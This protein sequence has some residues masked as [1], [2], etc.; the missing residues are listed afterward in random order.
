[1]SFK[2]LQRSGKSRGKKEDR[3]VF[4]L[5]CRAND[6]KEKY[7]PLEDQFIEVFEARGEYLGQVVLIH[8]GYWRPE[9][10]LAHLRPLAAALSDAGW[11]VQLIEY[12]RTPGIPDNYI[13]DVRAAII[14]GGGGI[15]IGHSAGGYL[16]LLTSNEATSLLIKGI[17]A[18]APISDLADAEARNL[19]NGA[20]KNYL[21]DSA[22]NRSDLDPHV[23]LN[24]SVPIVIIH[25]S[26]DQRV[27]I[28][29]S[30]NFN[31]SCRRAGLDCTLF[32]IEKIGHFELI[33]YRKSSFKIILTQLKKLTRDI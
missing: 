20:V 5:T 28:D 13:D 11:R 23:L 6:S 2:F 24:A 15:L 12:R 4:D 31:I 21:G 14:Y 33:D 9:F 19:D 8:G 10:D 18:L 30:R 27:P 26:E 7:G 32:E 16:A 22:V 1:M 25:G 29:M 17:I 3:S